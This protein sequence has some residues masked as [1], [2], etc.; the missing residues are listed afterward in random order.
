[1]LE[2]LPAM[3]RRSGA[4][5]AGACAATGGRVL[6][7]ENGKHHVK[8]WLDKIMSEEIEHGTISERLILADGTA[9]LHVWRREYPGLLHLVWEIEKSPSAGPVPG[10]QV[11]TIIPDA[12]Y[13]R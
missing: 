9:W 6:R 1:V 4:G 12:D 2:K 7:E 10:S 11:G 3:R 13:E 8:R 5:C